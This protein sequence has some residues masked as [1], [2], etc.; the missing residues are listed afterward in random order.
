MIIDAHLVDD[1]MRLQNVPSSRVAPLRGRSS[2]VPRLMAFCF[3]RP[4]RQTASKGLA[5]GGG[6]QAILRDLCNSARKRLLG[7]ANSRS[8]SPAAAKFVVRLISL[9]KREL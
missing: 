7:R 3:G 6:Q 9:E 5:L 8:A 2:G 4:M 1:E